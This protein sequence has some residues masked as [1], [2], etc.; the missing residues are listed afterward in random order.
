[1]AQVRDAVAAYQLFDANFPKLFP[2]FNSDTMDGWP[3]SMHVK[4]GVHFLT[5]VVTGSRGERFANF[6]IDN[7]SVKKVKEIPADA[8]LIEDEIFAL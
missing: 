5:Y 6:E 4:D 8:E 7:G 3:D 2:R 1:M